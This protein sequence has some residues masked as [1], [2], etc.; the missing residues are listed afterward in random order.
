MIWKETL[1]TITMFLLLYT[2]SM[3][4]VTQILLPLSAGAVGDQEKDNLLPKISE[5]SGIFPGGW[6]HSWAV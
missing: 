6:G 3:I 5:V 2:I 1:Y 4:P